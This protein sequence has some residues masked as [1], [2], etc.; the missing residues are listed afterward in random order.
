MLYVSAPQLKLI[1]TQYYAGLKLGLEIV[2]IVKKQVVNYIHRS[3]CATIKG[4]KLHSKPFT[5]PIIITTIITTT[6]LLFHYTYY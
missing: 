4:I 6:I 5:I 2:T 1:S 3:I